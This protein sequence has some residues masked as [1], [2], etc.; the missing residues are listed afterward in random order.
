MWISC[1]IWERL[2]LCLFIFRL[3]AFHTRKYFI[4]KQRGFSR[5][6]SRWELCMPNQEKEKWKLSKNSF[7]LDLFIFCSELWLLPFIKPETNDFA[8]SLESI[9][10]ELEIAWANKNQFYK[11]VRLLPSLVPTIVYWTENIRNGKIA[12]TNWCLRF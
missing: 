11:Q 2:V 6:Q 10:L 3:M 1:R 9:G 7:V 5:Y 12:F 8:T 4:N